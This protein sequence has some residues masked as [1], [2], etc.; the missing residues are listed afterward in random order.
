M[1][2]LTA[3]GQTGLTGT[4]I[5]TVWA[6][7][8]ASGQTG[9]EGQAGAPNLAHPELAAGS[10]GF[11]GAAFLSI[12]S[13]PTSTPV[14]PSTPVGVLPQGGAVGAIFT[15]WAA[16]RQRSVIEHVHWSKH[17]SGRARFADTR[18]KW[19]LK[20]ECDETTAGTIWSFILSHI[21]PASA[22]YFYDLEQIGVAYDPT[23]VV[24]TGR[25]TCRF[26]N[27]VFPR[28]YRKGARYTFEFRIIEV[29]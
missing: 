14:L 10:T 23:G 8:I 3:E 29:E 1:P 15:G 4:F 27:D 24:T 2:T 12:V 17:L 18:H 6:D 7:K 13:V 21:G 16:Q 20:I 26:D 5:V 22:F 25:Y 11:T 9:F 19:D 28:R